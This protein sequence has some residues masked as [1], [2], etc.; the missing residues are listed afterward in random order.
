M[1]RVRRSNGCHP[2]PASAGLSR[3]LGRHCSLLHSEGTTLKRQG[4][5]FSG[6]TAGHQSSSAGTCRAVGWPSGSCLCACTRVI[7]LPPLVCAHVYVCVCMCAC[8]VQG[9]SPARAP[10][11]SFPPLTGAEA[12]GHLPTCS[13]STWRSATSSCPSPRPPLS[14]PAASTNGGSLGRQVDR[15]S[16]LPFAEGGRFVAGD[17]HSQGGPDKEVICSSVA[18]S[19]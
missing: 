14:S 19:R 10:A 6:C 18:E 8:L 7:V 2:K 13:L 1:Q 5:H 15:H 4:S 3:A 17:A 11:D 16:R 9:R 12:S